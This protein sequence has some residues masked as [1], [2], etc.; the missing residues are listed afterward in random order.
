MS[1]THSQTVSCPGCAAPLE[2]ELRSSV[3]A[4]RHPELRTAILGGTLQRL[5]C[6]CGATVRVAPE[7]SY[8]DTERKQWLVARPHERLSAWR[9][10][11]AQAQ[12][13][14]DQA[15]GANAPAVAQELGEGIAPRLV[16]G[17]A[18]LTEKLV[19]SEA[20]LDDVTLECLKLRLMKDKGIV[21]VAGQELRLAGATSDAL[22]LCLIDV[23]KEG[24]VIRAELKRAAYD[25]I[26]AAP[27]AWAG[28]RAPLG[29]G[30]FVDAQKLYYGD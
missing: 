18:A 7:L 19:A 9:E 2:F 12:A 23:V 28:M 17:W 20:G 11:E 25:A 26:E 8:L 4:T 14:Y 3:N 30:L 24:V 15:L 5:E 16:F 22:E 27:E 29:E 21:P 6:A 10:E 1:R 13:L